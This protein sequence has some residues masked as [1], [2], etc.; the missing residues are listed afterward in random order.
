[1]SAKGVSD[2]SAV[3]E[4]IVG[5]ELEIIRD[6]VIMH[7]RTHEDVAPGVI[8]DAEFQVHQKVAA[9]DVRA[10]TSAVQT[11]ISWGIEDQCFAADAADEIPV[12][13]R[14]ES[15]GVD[16]VD[17]V[18]DGTEILKIVVDAFLIAECA[19]DAEAKVPLI[20]MLER[21]TG[22]GPSF[23]GGREKGFGGGF[24]F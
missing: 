13:F 1:V 15:P 2:R 21:E 23:F 9:I 11:A 8:A 19:L 24:V 17:V 22:I 3:A 12:G 5:V 18:E 4:D 10:T 6:E 16:S 7:F 14:S 20:E